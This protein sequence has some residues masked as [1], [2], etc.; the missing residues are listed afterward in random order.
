LA[1]HKQ[2]KFWEY[3]EKL[4]KLPGQPTDAQLIAT[5]EALK[6]D[7]KKF[8]TDRAS[9]AVAMQVNKDLMDASKSGAR[10]TPYFFVNGMPLSGAL[11]EE[12]FR[13]TIDAAL[14][15]TQ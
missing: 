1:A 8:N 15:D 2:G 9:P 7:M 11:P 5:A 13:A 14:K 6:L 3:A 10:G 4:W 12:E